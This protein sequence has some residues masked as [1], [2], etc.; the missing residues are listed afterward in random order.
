MAAVVQPRRQR[1]VRAGPAL[2]DDHVARHFAG[3]A[4]PAMARH[5]VQRQVDTRRDA[6]AGDQVAVFDEDAIVLNAGG[7]V[8]AGQLF[9][10][11]VVRG[12]F[13]L[14]GEARGGGEQRARA[15]GHQREAVGGVPDGQ[16]VHDG[17]R[18]EVFQPGV[19]AHHAGDDDQCVGRQRGRQGLD[20][21]QMQP[22]NTA[23]DVAGGA[24]EVLFERARAKLVGDAER[25]RRARQVQQ[26]D[27]LRQHEVHRDHARLLRWAM[28]PARRRRGRCGQ[29]APAG[30]IRCDPGF[31]PA[32][33]ACRTGSAW[34]R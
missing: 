15:D 12:A 3:G 30:P 20:M 6:R 9:Q 2:I 10:A 21:R 29:S 1:G 18:V 27:T 25:F 8:D 4:R 14:P 5:H 7:G 28:S 33:S 31:R 24:A 34:Q 11:G 17:A 22:G 13:A 26:D 19:L 32:C 16:P 23:F